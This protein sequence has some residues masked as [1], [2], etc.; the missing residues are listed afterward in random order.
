MYYNQS[1]LLI[2]NYYLQ[3]IYLNLKFNRHFKKLH[4]FN[5]HRMCIYGTTN[6]NNYEMSIFHSSQCE[7]HVHIVKEK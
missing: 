6:T 5:I 4:N 1:Y 7:L 2:T 3:N